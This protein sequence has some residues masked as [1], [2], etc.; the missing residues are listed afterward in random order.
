V[1]LISLPHCLTAPLPSHSVTAWP[2]AADPDPKLHG[3]AMQHDGTSG[4]P[5]LPCP[6]L[7]CPALPCPAL[8]CPALPCPALPC[9]ALPCPALPCHA[10]CRVSAGLMGTLAAHAH[11]GQHLDPHPYACPSPPSPVEKR[12]SDSRKQV[13][14]MCRDP[15]ASMQ[16]MGP[17]FQ[18]VDL[19]QINYLK[20]FPI[21]DMPCLTC[22]P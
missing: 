10:T 1:L 15:A 17:A 12:V 16:C 22:H 13:L 4:C 7:P 3:L 8:P 14:L 5:A 9:P 2:P 11:R 21:I 6:A 18:M 20:R 19:P